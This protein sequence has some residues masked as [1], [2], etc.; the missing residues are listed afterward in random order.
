MKK[1]RYNIIAAVLLLVVSFTLSGCAELFST[2]NVEPLP[3]FQNYDEMLAYLE[4][5]GLASSYLK[6]GG[7]SPGLPA[8][9]EEAA[10]DS[11]GNSGADRGSGFGE[12]NVQTS[13][14][15]EAD[16]IKNDGR[17]IYYLNDNKLVIVDAM[18]PSD[19]KVTGKITIGDSSTFSEMYKS[20]DYITAIGYTYEEMPVEKNQ[21]GEDELLPGRYIP[22]RT[23]VFANVY[24]IS[25]RTNPVLSREYKIE[26]DLLSSRMMDGKL[27]LVTN[28]WTYFY[29]GEVKPSQED[30][31]P[32]VFDSE[33]N[34]KT[35]TI[36]V[37]QICFMP[38]PAD[39]SIMTI[40]VMDTNNSSQVKTESI[41]GGGSNVYMSTNAL[42]IVKPHMY[43]F[44]L[45]ER[46]DIDPETVSGG[47]EATSTD[48]S[49]NEE[50]KTQIHKYNLTS[51]SVSYAG[52]GEVKGD[53]LNQFSMD[54]FNG[55]FRIATTLWTQE[56]TLNNVYVL[57]SG[58]NQVGEIE[59]LAPGERIY[60]VRFSGET[61]YVVTFKN[62]DPLFVLDLSNPA[63]PVVTGEL[64]IPGFSNYLHPVGD[65][66][67]VGIGMDTREIYETG[68]NGE[69]VVT[70]VETGG[71]KISLFDVSNPANPVEKDVIVLGGQGS[72]TDAQYNHK[73][74]TW[75]PEKSVLAFSAMVNT[76]GDMNSRTS[77]QEH[78]VLIEVGDEGLSLKG[79]L[80]SGNQ[81]DQFWYYTQS[82]VTYIGETVYYIISG[83]MTSYD[84]ETLAPLG[85][86]QIIEI[87]PYRYKVDPVPEPVEPEDAPDRTPDDE[88]EN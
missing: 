23:Y 19:M 9:Q 55:Y 31:L 14:V 12:T 21:S 33:K 67:L 63:N 78:A 87:E 30:V 41:M 22:S 10:V 24:D 48:E 51:N 7:I 69:M 50:P 49:E 27:Y 46:V 37:E 68:K 28:K 65:N 71:I 32:H 38:N 64:K 20:G 84:Y 58:M 36:P 56:G 26:G 88:V 3:R 6:G 59:G 34:D 74:V 77:W 70:R 18:N 11:N 81:N 25:D 72:H 4:N 43:F 42:Y 40:S 54:E 17:Y 66:L 35:T 79:M 13:G 85:A 16:V 5:S 53:I 61:G 8:M 1:H 75:W 80:P 15:D 83:N 76:S 47:S 73:A 57:D 2:E 44:P 62:V 60:S 86:V 45:L 82:R 39:S 52:Y 29:G